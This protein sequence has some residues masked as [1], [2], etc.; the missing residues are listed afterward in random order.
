MPKGFSQFKS[1]AKQFGSDVKSKTPFA[2]GLIILIVVLVLSCLVGIIVAAV[3]GYK[4]SHKTTTSTY[5]VYANTTYPN[6]DLSNNVGDV[7]TCESTCDSNNA[8]TGFVTDGTTCWL[9]DATVTTP[10]YD[11]SKVYY[12]KSGTPPGPATAPTVPTYQSFANTTYPEGDLSNT[13]GDVTACQTKCEETDKC[14]GFVTDGTTCWLKDLSVATPTYDTKKTYYYKSGTPKGPATTPT[15][16]IPAGADDYQKYEKTDFTF[17]GDLSSAVGTVDTCKTSCNSMENCKGFVTDGTTCYFKS[18]NVA[19][20]IYSANSTFYYKGITPP[21]PAVVPSTPASKTAYGKYEYTDY[22]NQGDISHASGNVELCKSTCNSLN[23]CTGFSTDGSTCW[24]KNN[25]VN[26]PSF[27]PILTYY[28]N[29]TPPPGPAT[30][31]SAKPITDSV[32]TESCSSNGV[33]CASTIKSPDGKCSA[34]LQS[35]GNLVI[36]NSSQKPIWATNTYGKGILPVTSIMQADG[37]YVIYDA[38]KKATWMSGSSG[39]G[40]GAPYTLKMQNDCNLVVY[41]KNNYPAWATGTY[42][43]Q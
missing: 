3:Y 15:V 8:C 6:G 33:N 20:P 16:P 29:G 39:K 30:V 21:G 40:A 25:T 36:F 34:V 13:P 18:A 42:G 2:I 19:V 38:N 11:T 24:Y 27:N 12:Y 23:S 35:D 7:A 9:K 26:V 32:N 10:K 43:K 28:Y 41:D 5:Q 37:N 1:G 4:Y 14:T 31:P 22:S 17:Q